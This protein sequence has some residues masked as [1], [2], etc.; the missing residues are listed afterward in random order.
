MP[1][2]AETKTV[3][4]EHKLDLLVYHQEADRMPRAHDLSRDERA[5]NAYFEV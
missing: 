4:V 5:L 2:Y 3:S 1:G